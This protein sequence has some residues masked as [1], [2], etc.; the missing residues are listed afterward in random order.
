VDSA[1]SRKSAHDSIKTLFDDPEKF[2]ELSKHID[3][4]AGQLLKTN[5]AE[6]VT[7]TMSQGKQKALHFYRS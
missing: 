1:D 3:E 5:T 7:D 2:Q 4:M 6:F